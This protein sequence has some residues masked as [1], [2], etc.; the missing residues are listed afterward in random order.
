MLQSHAA[1]YSGRK[2][3]SFHGT[4]VQ[5]IQPQPTLFFSPSTIESTFTSIQR[6]IPSPEVLPSHEVL[7]TTKPHNLRCH[8]S[9]SPSSSPHKLGKVG[10]KRRRTASVRN[11][12]TSFKPTPSCFSSPYQHLVLENFLI[13]PAEQ[14]EVDSINN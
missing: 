4:T 13:S 6:A 9:Q 3:R 14:Q 5:L 7:P 8:I 11:F 2:D 10:P 1:V 12:E